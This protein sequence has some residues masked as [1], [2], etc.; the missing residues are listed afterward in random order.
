MTVS[1]LPKINAALNTVAAILLMAGF[2][3]IK[4]SHKTAHRN[5][6]ISALIC[7]TVFLAC[8]V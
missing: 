5:C 7:S 4:R 6:M 8:Y 3:F 2:I 1:D